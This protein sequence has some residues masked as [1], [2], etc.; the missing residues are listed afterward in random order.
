MMAAP[1]GAR[2]TH[3]DHASLPI[4][5]AETV[6]E[7]VACYAAGATVLHAHVRGQQHSRTGAEFKR[8]D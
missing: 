3:K 2:K 7:A 4:S 6:D 8:R 1:N 5:I